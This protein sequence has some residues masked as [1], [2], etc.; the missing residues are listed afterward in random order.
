MKLFVDG[1]AKLRRHKL[2]PS[3]F[4]R[5]MCMAWY[6]KEKAQL[7]NAPWRKALQRRNLPASD[8]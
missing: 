6:E 2:R 8:A 7:G 4:R 3:L 5:E 1:E